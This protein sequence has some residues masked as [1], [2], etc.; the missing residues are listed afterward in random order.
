MIWSDVKERSNLE[1]RF[2]GDPDF[3]SSLCPMAAS[4]V[5]INAGK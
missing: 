3:L 4:S 2:R 1:E 5:R